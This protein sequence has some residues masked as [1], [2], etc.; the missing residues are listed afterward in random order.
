M[1][2][3]DA[4][5]RAAAEA[6]KRSAKRESVLDRQWRRSPQGRGGGGGSGGTG[7]IAW[8][9]PVKAKGRINFANKTPPLQVFEE[10]ALRNRKRGESYGA[11]LYRGA[12]EHRAAVKAGT[13]RPGTKVLSPFGRATIVRQGKR[14]MTT[15]LVG[16]RKLSAHS[17]LLTTERAKK[18]RPYG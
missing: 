12:M 16:K 17:S 7:G 9:Y 5:R 1:A 4:A 15:V 2:W 3:S 8:S 11:A 10:D 14:G 6:R 13:A 18:P